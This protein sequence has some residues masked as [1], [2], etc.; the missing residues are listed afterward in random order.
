MAEIVIGAQEPFAV[1][2]VLLDDLFH[3][4]CFGQEAANVVLGAAPLGD[5]RQFLRRR[6]EQAPR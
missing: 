3:T 4:P 5:G 2:A 6:H 1:P